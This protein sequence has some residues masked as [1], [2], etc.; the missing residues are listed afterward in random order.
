MY[1][2]IVRRC[3]QRVHVHIYALKHDADVR[4]RGVGD[5]FQ[6]AGE[7]G[8]R[9]KEKRNHQRIAA[10][11]VCGWFGGVKKPKAAQKLLLFWRKPAAS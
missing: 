4:W 3:G 5:V 6:K 2:G 10:Y 9:Q 8:V 7:K 1:A 11:L